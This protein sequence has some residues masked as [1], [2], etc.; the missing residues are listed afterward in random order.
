VR[1]EANGRPLIIGVTGNIATGK[2]TVAAMLATLGADVIDADEV[3]H[4]TMRPG[5]EVHARVVDA[6]GPQILTPS[7]EIDRKA[8]GA[9][10]FGNPEALTRLEVIVHPTTLEKIDRRITGSRADVVAV[11]AIKLL[12]SGLSDV[13]ES[14]WV[15]TCRRAQQIERLV[16]HRKLR[17]D[18]ARRRVDAQGPQHEKVARA[19]VV[20]DNSGP[21]SV[22]RA[23]VE[24]AWQRVVAE[25]G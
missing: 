14:V 25:A 1:G 7:G 20:I 3:A 5:A 4:Q 2:S 11:E 19:D 24:A 15:T 8:L 16:S 22:T 10:V 21:L 13:C 23:Q 18:E 9:I 17:E 6:F 12:E